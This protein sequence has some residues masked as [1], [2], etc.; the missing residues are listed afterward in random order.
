MQLAMFDLNVFKLQ[1]IRSYITISAADK[2]ASL[3]TIRASVGWRRELTLWKIL[4]KPIA[5]NA[6][7]LSQVDHYGS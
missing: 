4:Q 2:Y 6:G 5:M 3:A 1:S 7:Q